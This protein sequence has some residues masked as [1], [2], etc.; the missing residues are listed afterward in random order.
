M[1]SATQKLG[2]LE[3]GAPADICIFDLHKEWAVDTDKFASKG[4]NTPLAGQ[5][6]KGKVMA[7]LYMGKPVYMD[8]TLRLKIDMKYKVR[9]II[10][11]EAGNPKNLDGRVD[12]DC[13]A[14][15]DS[16]SA[17]ALS[18]DKCKG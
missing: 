9:Q 15:S 16:W 13:H 5:T 11:E 1:S 6:L 4:K 10:P 18:D 14:C 8:E 7:T 17:I 12:R 2:T 3:I